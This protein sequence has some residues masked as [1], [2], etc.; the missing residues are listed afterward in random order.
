MSKEKKI[1]IIICIVSLVAL[2][3]AL[4]TN[5]FA[6]NDLSLLTQNNSN[7]NNNLFTNIAPT[8]SNTNKNLNSNLNSNANKNTNN[9]VNKNTN[10]NVVSMPDTGVDY[11]VVTI[12]AVCGIS[13]IY[14]YKKIRDYNKF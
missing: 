1:E 2:V 12:I 8:N 4:T 10:N 6:E 9:N 11:S 3:L 13:A 7:S 14:A 5:V